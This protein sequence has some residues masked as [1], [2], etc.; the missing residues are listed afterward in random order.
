M[1]VFTPITSPLMLRSG[2]PLFPWLIEASVWIKFSTCSIPSE[3]LPEAPITPTVI[4]LLSPN[5][6]PKAIAQ[7]PIFIL[8][9][10][11]NFN[12]LNVLLAFT[13]K[14]AISTS[15]D[16]PTNFAKYSCPSDNFT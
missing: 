9:E 6:F 4:E 5:G 11:A 16:V 14:I 12:G 8:S 15:G 2:P 1:A 7:C 10:F 13:F 3:L